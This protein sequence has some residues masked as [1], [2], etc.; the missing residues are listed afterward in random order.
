MLSTNVL[1][2]LRTR[3]VVVVIAAAALA[4]SLSLA[5]IGNSWTATAGPENPAEVVADDDM[6]LAGP[7]WTFSARATLPPPPTDYLGPSWG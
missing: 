5:A 3:R 4:A 7:S 2:W 6:T 1:P